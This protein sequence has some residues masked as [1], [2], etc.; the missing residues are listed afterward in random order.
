MPETW[1]QER[2]KWCQ[3]TECLFKRR[4]MD[5]ACVGHL[6]KPVQ[7]GADF[8]THRVCLNGAA[9][10]GGVFDLQ[11]ND[12]DIWWCGW[13]FESIKKSGKGDIMDIRWT[14][15]KLGVE[16]YQK[17]CGQVN[18]HFLKTKKP[19]LKRTMGALL[20]AKDYV[21]TAI[22][23]AKMSGGGHTMAD[24]ILAELDAALLELKSLE[25]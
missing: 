25:D 6:P 8:N 3:H 14:I 11:I 9:D 12:T 1:K 15:E 18:L 24:G 22:S 21:S 17:L 19:S 10:N 4:V 2:P 23:A 7:H 13:L 16:D 20:T 5:A